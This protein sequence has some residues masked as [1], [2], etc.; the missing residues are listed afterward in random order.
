MFSLRALQVSVAAVVFV[1]VDTLAGD[2]EAG[3]RL[4]WSTES[5]VARQGLAR[6]Q[7]RIESF[8]VALDDSTPRAQAFLGSYHVFKGEYS[9]AR[10]RFELSLSKV[11]ADAAPMTIRY[12]MAF[13]H[14]YEGNVDAALASLET[15]L[16]EYQKLLLARAYDRLGESAEAKKAYEEIVASTGDSLGRA[17]AY[18]EAKRMSAR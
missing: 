14:L 1:T 2:V 18:P 16:D 12:G 10:A 4:K 11:G 6:L 13:T 5:Q 15:Y 9:K 8:A 17:L 7:R 3:K